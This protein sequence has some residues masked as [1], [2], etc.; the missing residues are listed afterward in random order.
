MPGLPLPSGQAMHHPAKVRDDDVLLSYSGEEPTLETIQMPRGKVAF[1]ALDVAKSHAERQHALDCK[2][3]AAEA[4]G[5][6]SR[7]A[8]R[9]LTLKG[10]RHDA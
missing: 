5:G 2:E 7:V 4:A 1:T 6:E 3:G 8:G 9:H 10:C